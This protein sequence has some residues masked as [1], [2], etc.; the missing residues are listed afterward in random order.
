MSFKYMINNKHINVEVSDVRWM[1]FYLS[2]KKFKKFSTMDTKDLFKSD[3]ACF[4]TYN[5]NG[6]VILFPTPLHP[7]KIRVYIPLYLEKIL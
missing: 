3:V 4:F 1:P 6:D 2:P 7:E 5:K